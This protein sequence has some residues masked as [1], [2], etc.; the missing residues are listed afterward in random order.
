L[1]RSFPYLGGL[2]LFHPEVFAQCGGFDSELE[3]A[4]E[5]DLSLKVFERYGEHSIGHLSEL[6]YHRREGGG[7]CIE[8][9]EEIWARCRLALQG[10]LDRTQPGAVAHLGK[11]APFLRA[12]YPLDSLPKV[13]I[14]IPTKDKP[15]LIRRCLDSLLQLT[16]YPNFEVI[17]VDNQTTNVEALD[18]Y[19]TAIKDPRVRLIEYPHPFN[20]SAINNFAARQAGGE[21]LLLLNND[22]AVLDKNWLRTMMSYA[23]R[24]DVG[25][26]GPLLVFE[27]GLVQHAGL[28]LGLGY[29]PAEH[30]FIGLSPEEPG[31]FG[32]LQLTQNYAGVTGACLLIRKSIYDEVGGLNETDLAVSF[33]D[34]DLCLKVGDKGHKI[35]WTPETRLM[36]AASQSL[37]GMEEE[38]KKLHRLKL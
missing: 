9:A 34:V 12:E 29:Q 4:E 8:P 24:R 26:V 31:Y 14:I 23:Q 19:T 1:L 20:Y 32:R 37:K 13:S 18:Y 15:D 2:T 36:H 16:D 6:M 33:N 35:I 17:V 27:D 28:V 3:G 5:Y 30:L 38:A 11:E 21:Y 25:I 7:H 22:T 10:H